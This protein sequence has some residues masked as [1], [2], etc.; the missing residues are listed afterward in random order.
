M[1]HAV[2]VAITVQLRLHHSNL[3]RA[4][5]LELSYSCLEGKGTT[6]IPHPRGLKPPLDDFGYYTYNMVGKLKIWSGIR[7]SNSCLDLGKVS[8]YH[9]TNPA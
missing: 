7:E 9:Y 8:G 3:E 1:Q 6:F 5:R 4:K 2:R